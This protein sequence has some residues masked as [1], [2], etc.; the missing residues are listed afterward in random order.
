MADKFA[1]QDREFMIRLFKNLQR[2]ID[3]FIEYSEKAHKFK[4]GVLDHPGRLA[5][6]KK[7][8]DEDPN[9]TLTGESGQI[10]IQEKYNEFKAIYDYLNKE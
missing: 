8:I 4:M 6:L 9:Y 3:D 7:L 1:W 5:E 2:C 10:G